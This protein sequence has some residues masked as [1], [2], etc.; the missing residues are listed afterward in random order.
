[1]QKPIRLHKRARRVTVAALA[2]VMIVAASVF[3]T[4]RVGAQPTAAPVETGTAS[5]EGLEI[6][7]KAAFGRLEINSWSGVWVPFRITI[8]NQGPP[9]TGRLIVH[10]ESN[11]NGPS[12]SPREFVKDVQLPTGA[13]QSHEITA[14][15][16]SGENPIVR[17]MSGDRVL[18]ETTV[19]VQRNW[20]SDQLEVG[21]VDTDP[22][23]L[24]NISQSPVQQQPIREPFKLGPRSS[25]QQATNPQA[26]NAPGQPQR[27]GPRN[28][29]GGPQVFSTHPTVI[30]A[31]DLPR[32]FVAYD[33]L[34]A[35]VINDAPLSQLNEEQAR[36]LR[37][38]VA[39]GGVL[40]VAGGA[41][42]AGMRANRLDEIL[43]IDAGTAASAT[44]FP[45]AELAQVYG[46]FEA[47][48]ATLGVNARVRP[49]ARA[50][51]GT[52]DRATVAERD[53]GNGVVRFVAINPKLNPYRGWNGAK[54]L[55]ADLL[56]PAADAKPRHTNWITQGSRGPSRAGRFGVQDLLYHLAEL[57]PP[58]TKYV[59]FFLL[60]YVLLV[61]PVNYAVLRWRKKTD[62]AWLTIPAVVI[63]F[64]LVSVAVAQISHGGK[65]VVADASFVQVHQPEGISNVTSGLIVVSAAK[66]VQQIAFAGGSAYASDVLTPGG[67]ASS[68][69]GTECRRD[70]KEFVINAEMTTRS[71]SVFQLR[72][73]RES[74]PPVLA[75]QT[76]QGAVTL[77]NL[78]DA[79]IVKA[80]Y[81]SADGVSDV[82]E[83]NAG[84][85]QRV[86]L[87]SPP[88]QA[89]NVWYGSHIGQDDESELFNDLASVLDREVGG[90]P[91]FT[92]GFFET[93]AMSDALKKMR[94]P[95]VIC[96]VEKPAAEVA[97][98]D[99]FKRVSKTFCVIHL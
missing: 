11:N 53:Y 86:A 93:Q 8:I 59:I 54:E 42:L 40:I 45:V 10:T 1:M 72:A 67:S 23:A 55:W 12:S 82:F 19:A 66:E 36:A 44:G 24:N 13:N 76:A 39:S 99:N 61:G 2:L 56:W 69:G 16:N 58:S 97:F 32:D 75:A 96:F 74:E 5:N 63:L 70:A 27:R 91:A 68:S 95:L 50:L 18:V 31:D 41:D 92:Q 7:V 84:S 77:K 22:T 85:E 25:P 71:A 37:L 51:I 29:G 52:S 34:D 9:V 15:I 49:G 90:D 20:M 80:V 14:F 30:S 35:L 6:A 3:V 98:K 57:Q 88:A 78:G 43:P 21:V 60:A 65:A 47:A 38:W 26:P 46:G 48:E 33:A 83:L 89:F 4:R 73:V 64:T 79:P 94:R 17:I 62:L 28:F 81:L 87:N